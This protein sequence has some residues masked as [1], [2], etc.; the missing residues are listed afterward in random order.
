MDYLHTGAPKQLIHRDLKSS[1]IL[2]N[3]NVLKITD[4]GLSKEMDKTAQMSTVG[5]YAWMAPEIIKHEKCSEKVDIW[6]YGVVLWELVTRQVRLL[7]FERGDLSVSS[8]VMMLADPV[9][10]HRA[11]RHCFQYWPGHFAA[12][13]YARPPSERNAVFA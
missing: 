9:P 12:A 10:R 3:G 6:S 8:H 2:V 4:F 11:G 13:V 5:T 1:N 7:R